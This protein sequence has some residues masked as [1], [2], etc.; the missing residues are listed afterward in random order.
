MRL[1]TRERLAAWDA[2]YGGGQDD[3][4][5]AG[6]VPSDSSP[7]AA[8]G[9]PGRSDEAD[10][11]AP[12]GHALAQLHGVYLLAQNQQGLVLVDIHAAHERIVYERMKSAWQQGRVTAQP[13]LVPVPLAVSAREADAAEQAADALARVGVEDRPARSGIARGARGYQRCLPAP[14]CR[15]WCAMCS[16]T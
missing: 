6:R 13:L 16:R 2:L 4:R 5:P 7:V 3:G 9:T 14:M 11:G 15:H 1:A 12:L 8:A 10:D